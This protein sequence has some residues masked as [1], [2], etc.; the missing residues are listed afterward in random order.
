MKSRPITTKGIIYS[1]NPNPEHKYH[2]NRT[3]ICISHAFVNAYATI[4]NTHGIPVAEQ[5]LYWLNGKALGEL[6]PAIERREHGG[7]SAP[8][9][10][11]PGEPNAES[12]RP[13]CPGG[14]NG[15]EA[16]GEVVH[17]VH[18]K[19]TIR[20]GLVGYRLPARRPEL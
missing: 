15:V 13:S 19:S 20:S 3:P 18:R 14:R 9:T 16:P 2:A 4:N 17:P 5:I 1:G 10:S 6:S 11:S 7:V 12:R 8:P